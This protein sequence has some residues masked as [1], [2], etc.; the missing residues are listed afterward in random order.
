MLPSPFTTPVPD[1]TTPVSPEPYF[2]AV[3]K[4]AIETLSKFVC[5]STSIS[6]LISAP[7]P[8]NV[9]PLNVVDYTCI[10]KLNITTTSTKL[11]T[12]AF[13]SVDTPIT[14]TY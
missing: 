7:V 14:L 4:P 6:P 2:V 12:I 8:K 10:T 1:A 9:P 5:P 11:F 3:T 13:L